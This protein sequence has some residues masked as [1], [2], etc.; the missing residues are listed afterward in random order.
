MV[1]LAA[2]FAGEDGASAV[3]SDCAGDIKPA[4]PLPAPVIAAPEPKLETKPETKL[5]TKSEAKPDAKPETKPA[6]VVVAP[7]VQ[8]PAPVIVARPT[9]TGSRARRVATTPNEIRQSLRRRRR[10][11]EPEPKPAPV[12]VAPPAPEPEA[13]P[14][15]SS[16]SLRPPT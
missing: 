12:V 7:P 2:G 11:V 14:A 9:E 16:P 4:E 10:P 1:Q 6:P 15:R 3:L 13:K 8:T 5:E